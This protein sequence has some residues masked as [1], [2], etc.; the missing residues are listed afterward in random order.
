MTAPPGQILALRFDH[1]VGKTFSGDLSLLLLA[2]A[3]SFALVA[4]DEA[5]SQSKLH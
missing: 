4:E 1:I 3:K 5:F 2:L